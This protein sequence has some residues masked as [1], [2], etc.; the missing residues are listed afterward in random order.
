MSE[1]AA[2][3][4]TSTGDAQA[5]QAA[6]ATAAGTGSQGTA[7]DATAAATGDQS[8]SATGTAP[9]A[10]APAAGEK[11]AAIEYT[12]FK[13]P[14]G[15]TLTGEHADKFKTLAKEMSLT[16]EQAQKLV[17]LDAQKSL[18]HV[19]TLKQASTS[20]LAAAK[21]D[22]EIGGDTFDVNLG[23]ANKALEAFGSP[24]FR[25]MLD[26]TGFS[27]HPEV[28]RTFYKVGKAISEDG[29]V[30]GGKANAGGSDARG[31]FPNSNMN[32]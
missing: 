1:Q 16:Q 21:T 8:A 2:A 20:W 29:F 12:D 30:P 5:A 23:I 11:P 9:A 27:N 13:V 28:I 6:S 4:E 22:K 3:T 14:D 26:V 19:E 17:D 10:A 7:T 15:Y 18:A 31:M 32:P 24:E 25:K